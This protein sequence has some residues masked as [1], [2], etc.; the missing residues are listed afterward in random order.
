MHSERSEINKSYRFLNHAFSSPHM[1]SEGKEALLGTS[2]RHV[3][4][5]ILFLSYSTSFIM[6]PTQNV[7]R[8]PDGE[9]P[10]QIGSLSQS[11]EE[12]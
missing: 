5:W 3:F 10:Q 2:A 9:T 7:H 8:G 11:D 12:S 4:W 6:C 1:H